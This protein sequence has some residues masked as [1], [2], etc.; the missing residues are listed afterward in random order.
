VFSVLVKVLGGNPV[1]PAPVAHLF[2]PK[3]GGA[4]LWKQQRYQAPADYATNAKWHPHSEPGRI[5]PKPN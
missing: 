3:L 5:G 1:T 4:K 2:G